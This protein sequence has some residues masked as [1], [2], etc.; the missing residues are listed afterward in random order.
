MSNDDDPVDKA[1]FWCDGVECRAQK[2]WKVTVG[3]NLP[4]AERFL[5]NQVPAKTGDKLSDATRGSHERPHSSQHAV[6]PTAP[7]IFILHTVSDA[8]DPPAHLVLHDYQTHSLVLRLAAGMAS[9]SGAAATNAD[10][11]G[12]DGA[13]SVCLPVVRCR[14]RH[15]V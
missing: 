3:I 15:S 13:R 6:R 8:T 14:L 1:K 11:V 2:D 9:S 7:F 10:D 12:M 5:A 4:K